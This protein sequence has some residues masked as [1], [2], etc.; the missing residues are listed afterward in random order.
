M[1]SLLRRWL[2][3]WFPPQTYSKEPSWIDPETVK[4]IRALREGKR[5]TV[6]PMP[7]PKRNKR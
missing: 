5:S 4:V 6:E 7:A 3:F 1:R 2:T